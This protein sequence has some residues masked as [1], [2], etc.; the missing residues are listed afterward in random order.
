M[1][2]SIPAALGPWTSA[3]DTLYRPMLTAERVAWLEAAI[4]SFLYA[5]VK[6][7]PGRRIA[8]GGTVRRVTVTRK[9]YATLLKMAE[10]HGMS[11]NALVSQVV[12][13][14]LSKGSKV[15]ILP[16][17]PWLPYRSE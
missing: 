13:A 12:V 11:V 10:T 9:M 17:D 1:K 5:P 7:T 14:F 3:F 16:N 8:M 4:A 15:V 6:Q 2:Y